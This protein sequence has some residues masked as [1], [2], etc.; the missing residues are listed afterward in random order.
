M[1]VIIEFTEKNGLK[2]FK[3]FF[4]LQKLEATYFMILHGVL[5]S[6]YTTGLIC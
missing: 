4:E 1:T 3:V 6:A 2:T 5:I